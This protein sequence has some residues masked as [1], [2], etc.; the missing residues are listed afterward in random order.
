[1]LD[2]VMLLQ[3][4]QA[5][6][7]VAKAMAPKVMSR[8]ERVLRLLADIEDQIGELVRLCEDPL[9]RKIVSDHFKHLEASMA[10]LAVVARVIPPEPE[11]I[12]TESARE[13]GQ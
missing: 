5:V 3:L 8:R 13:V 4:I 11:P 10:Q 12:P 1:M 9:L 7:A 2:D 6:D